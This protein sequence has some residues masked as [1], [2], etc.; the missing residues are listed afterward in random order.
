LVVAT[1]RSGVVVFLGDGHG[2]ATRKAYFSGIAPFNVAVAD[3]NGD[4]SLDIVVA[5]ES[6]IA[7]LRGRGTVSVFFGDGHGTFPRRTTLQADSY[8][9]DVKVADLNGDKQLDLAVVNWRSEN[10]SLFF[11][12]GDGTFTGARSIAYGGVPAYSLAIADLDHNGTPDLAV[13]DLQGAVRVLHNDGTGQFTVGEPL[14]AGAG[15]RTVITAD[16]NGDGLPDLATANT[17]ANT[18]T[19][20]LALPAGGFAPPYNIAVGKQPRAVAAADL[21]GDGKLDLVVTNSGSDDLSVLINTG[22]GG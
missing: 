22:A 15:L 5:D 17:L 18:A 4:G 20:L 3:L 13:G 16:L 19:V 12:H 11:G 14:N 2:G 9:A 8:P 10:V 7:A 1:V 6:N 21:N